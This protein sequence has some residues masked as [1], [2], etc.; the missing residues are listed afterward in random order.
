MQNATDA[1]I[2]RWADAK[3]KIAELRANE[4]WGYVR[5]NCMQ[6][7]ATM[8]GNVITDILEET[9]RDYDI[10]LKQH[11]E[12]VDQ[13]K[14]DTELKLE[15]QKAKNKTLME[16]LAE[17]KREIRLLQMSGRAKRTGKA[18]IE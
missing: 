13:T 6:L 18:Q 8:A 4:I 12:Y 17:A 2:K 3:R 7:D 16:E 11:I 10:K 5:D 15:L 14:R 1:T 9:A